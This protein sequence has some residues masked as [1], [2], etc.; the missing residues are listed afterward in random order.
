[1]I[2]PLHCNLGDRERHCLKRKK[3]KQIACAQVGGRCHG[4]VKAH[5]RQRDPCDKLSEQDPMMWQPR[6]SGAPEAGRSLGRY[7]RHGGS[8]AGVQE[9]RIQLHQRV[10]GRVFRK[11]CSILRVSPCLG[12]CRSGRCPEEQKLL[13]T[14]PLELLLLSGE[15]WL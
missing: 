1:M 8:G 15:A 3:C 7:L 5:Y 12:L 10:V 4:R 6:S 11:R 2:V 14:C 9:K 13:R